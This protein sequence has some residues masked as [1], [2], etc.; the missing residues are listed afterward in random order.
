M[1]DFASPVLR[2]TDK[3]R[4]SS[5]GILRQR[6]LSLLGIALS[7]VG[8]IEEVSDETRWQMHVGPLLDKL[9]LTLGDGLFI[10]H[11]DE[12]NRQN[13]HNILMSEFAKTAM[14]NY[15]DEAK[16]AYELEIC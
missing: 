12:P 10:A 11:N 7:Y 1:I 9:R 15:Y 8:L 5:D 13:A 16:S 14:K 2:T 6:I 3:L 4:K